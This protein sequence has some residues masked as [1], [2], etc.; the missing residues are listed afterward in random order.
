MDGGN[1]KCGGGRQENNSLE[2]IRGI[3]QRISTATQSG[4][5]G[6]H[7]V[8]LQFIK[9]CTLSYPHACR[10]KPSIVPS[11]ATR[12]SMHTTSITPYLLSN[13]YTLSFSMTFFL[14]P[15]HY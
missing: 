15:L 13:M 2:V 10:F 9:A 1:R 3:E 8:Q 5:D 4:T 11:K 14:S 12:K 7:G 6:G